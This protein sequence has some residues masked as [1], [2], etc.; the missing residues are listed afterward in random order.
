MTVF[1]IGYGGRSPT[2]LI[3]LLRAG[4]DVRQQNPL[5]VRPSTR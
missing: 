2:E 4:A 1:T 5:S 3:D